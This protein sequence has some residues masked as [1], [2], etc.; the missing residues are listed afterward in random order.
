MGFNLTTD[1]VC[2]ERETMGLNN[3]NK[4]KKDNPKK[5]IDNNGNQIFEGR[6][7]E[8]LMFIKTHFNWTARMIKRGRWK[9]PFKNAGYK[10]I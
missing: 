2:N 9:K 5:I 4:L 10:I 3:P 6:R 8:R 1:D 7:I